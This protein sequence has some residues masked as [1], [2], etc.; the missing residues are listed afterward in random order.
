M[1]LNN[2]SHLLTL[3]VALRKTTSEP[4]WQMCEGNGTRGMVM[5]SAGEK[6]EKKAMYSAFVLII[7]P[8]LGD[9]QA[10]SVPRL[11]FGRRVISGSLGSVYNILPYRTALRRRR[12][13]KGEVVV[14]HQYGSSAW[15]PSHSRLGNEATMS[16]DM[17]IKYPDLHAE[18]EPDKLKG[19]K[20]MK[21]EKR[22]ESKGV[23]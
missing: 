19:V 15:L 14:Q 17:R 8:G 4:C 3:S 6:K 7:P 2:S 1:F 23:G 5:G 22:S 9:I 10:T 20:E 12:E 11:G 21:Q 13:G 16:L 18:M